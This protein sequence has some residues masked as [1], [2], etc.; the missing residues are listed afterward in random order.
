[1]TSV[2]RPPASAVSATWGE[3]Q[4]TCGSTPPGVTIMPVASTTDVA[5]S[6]TTS[7]P[8]IV[9]G[10]PARPMA[11]IRPPATLRLVHRTPS[12]GSARSPPTIAIST[13]PRS[14]RTP[15]PS[16]IVLPNPGR[17]RSGPPQSSASGTSHRSESA[18]RTPSGTAVPPLP[19]TG[20]RRVAR[21]YGVERPVGEA[22]VPADHPGA[23][24]PHE[25]DLARL[26]GG[27]ED[28]LAGRDREPH[29]PRRRAVEA[30]R[31]VRLEEVEVAGHPDRHGALVD[32]GQRVVAR[33]PAQ[34]R[35]ALRGRGVR[36]H[37]VVQHDQPAAVGEQRLDLDPLHERGHPVGHVGRPQ[38]AVSG[39][40]RL[41][42]RV[43]VARRLDDLV[44]DQRGGL[45]LVEP[46]AAR[47]P[48][49]RQLGGEEE[50]ETVLL[51][52]EEAHGRGI[53]SRGAGARRTGRSS[54]RWNEPGASR[55]MTGGHARATT[56]RRSI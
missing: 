18:S 40:L 52:R 54:V 35:L 2:V 34:L 26:A 11:T 53:L 5:V 8:S 20:Q 42:V 56:T 32:H 38:R 33:G 3:S 6:S 43:S 12:T 24:E 1:M 19:R 28:L 25:L 45:R 15:S 31:A 36:G 29:A 51:A 22:R 13:P 50:E 17:I 14:A 21:P 4:W 10:L 39:G 55:V 16:R 47:A 48:L 9:S 27:E 7:I 44:G 46:Q 30:Q 23:A 49:A 41:G 37:R